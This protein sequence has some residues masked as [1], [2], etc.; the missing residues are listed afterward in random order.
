MQSSTLAESNSMAEYLAHQQQIA[1][2]RTQEIT[3]VSL[4]ESKRAEISEA[5]SR[6]PDISQLTEQRQD[7]LADLALGKASAEQVSALDMEIKS[8]TAELN[9]IAAESKHIKDMAEHAICGLGRRLDSIQAEI[10][11]LSDE[12]LNQRLIQAVL[13]VHAESLGED[14]VKAA[15]QTAALYMRLMPLSGLL[16]THGEKNGIAA[17]CSGAFEIPAFNLDAC[18]PYEIRNWP[19]NLFL[20]QI[21]TPGKFKEVTENEREILKAAGLAS[22]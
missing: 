8:R 10:A 18:R 16:Q 9:R 7:L 2:L 22:L 4:I 12:K 13:R 15:N 5:N 20:A 21:L 1:E 11:A 3:L 19:G 14:Y 6:I 17:H